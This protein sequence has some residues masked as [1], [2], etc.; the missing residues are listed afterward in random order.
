MSE[1]KKVS[2]ETLRNMM[3]VFI[4]TDMMW[5]GE[6]FIDS[7]EELMEKKHDSY[8]SVYKLTTED[9]DEIEGLIKEFRTTQAQE[10]AEREKRRLAEE[11]ADEVVANHY[12]ERIRKIIMSKPNDLLPKPTTRKTKVPR[13]N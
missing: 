3:R 7:W 9:I 11:E 4:K 1:S 12:A 2:R 10:Q 5:E 13:G 8:I 6:D